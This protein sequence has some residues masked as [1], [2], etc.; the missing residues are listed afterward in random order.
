MDV[1]QCEDRHVEPAEDFDEGAEQPVPGRGGVLQRFRGGGQVVGPLGEQ[2][3]QRAAQPAQPQPDNVVDTVTHRVHDRP[4]R[5][6][7]PQ[8]RAG[9]DQGAPAPLRLG[10]QE[11]AQQPGLADARLTV[12][13]DHRGG[14]PERRSEC[15]QL[16]VPADEPRRGQRREPVGIGTG[17]S[18][19]RRTP[20][21]DHRNVSAD[22]I[23]GR[24]FGW[25]QRLGQLNDGR[26]RGPRARAPPDI[27]VTRSA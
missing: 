14:L 11:L 18:N 21:V 12:E 5:V 16:P 23:R 3:P 26:S 20:S 4:E 17:P 13:Q 6:R 9:P 25:R 10:R 27:R 15:V 24:S 8:L 19:H 2:R 1:L 7:H 22:P